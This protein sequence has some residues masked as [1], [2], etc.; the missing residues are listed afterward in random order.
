MGVSC[1]YWQ[2]GSRRTLGSSSELE[3]SLIL[4]LATDAAAAA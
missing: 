1:A 4:L 2:I 3:V